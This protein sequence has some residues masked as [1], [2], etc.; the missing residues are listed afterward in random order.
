MN[1]SLHFF[2]YFLDGLRL[3]DDGLRFLLRED[4]VVEEYSQKKNGYS[5]RDEE[6][7]P[8]S[9][10]DDRRDHCGR[11]QFEKDIFK[12]FGEISA[13]IETSFRSLIETFHDD[14]RKAV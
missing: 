4:E 1:Y 9:L 8:G 6:R 13:A 7:I 12:N 2:F 14:L 10:F 11:V 5:C 3:R